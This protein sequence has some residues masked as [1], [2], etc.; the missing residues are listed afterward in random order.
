M[1]SKNKEEKKNKKSN[2]IIIVACII[3]VLLI[4]L[5]PIGLIIFGLFM[6]SS[7]YEILADGSV[8]INKGDLTIK[9]SQ[10]GE[11]NEKEECYYVEG[12]LVNNTDN[13]Y[14]YVD[15]TYTFY[16]DNGYTLGN[17]TAYLDKLDKN[18]TWKYKVSYCDIDSSDVTDFKFNSVYLSR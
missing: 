10:K 18:G 1:D 9:A 16:D 4:N 11:Y 7:S 17:S 6:D 12:L 5:L 8:S 2:V 15:L 3:L 14:E 13:V